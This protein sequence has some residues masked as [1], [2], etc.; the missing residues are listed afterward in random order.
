MT[1]TVVFL[2]GFFEVGEKL[3]ISG[4]L[5]RITSML[6]P[7]T[8][9]VEPYEPTVPGVAKIVSPEPSWDDQAHWRHHLKLKRICSDP[10]L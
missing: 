5:Y 6:R 3:S 10:S 8:Y 7:G 9:C 1:D 4:Q 2:G